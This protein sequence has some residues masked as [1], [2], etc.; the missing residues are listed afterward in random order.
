[1]LDGVELS[2]FKAAERN[3]FLAYTGHEQFLFSMSIRDNILFSEEDEKSL[4]QALKAAALSDDLARFD[5]GLATLVGEKGMRVS[6]G[7]RQRIALARAF[8]SAT[9]ILLLDDPFSAVDI[10]TE[11]EIIDCLK[12]DYSDRIILLFTH[13]LTAFLHADN[14]LVLEKGS[15]LQSGTHAALMQEKGLYQEIYNAQIFMEVSADAETN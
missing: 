7:Q 13:R 6:G 3:R 11:S 9:P 1:M 8:C 15:I 4:Q 10:A 2:H 12:R 14:I 5:N